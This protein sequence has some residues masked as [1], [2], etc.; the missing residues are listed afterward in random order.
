LG[1]LFFLVAIIGTIGNKQIKIR[2]TYLVSENAAGKNFYSNF[3]YNLIKI[4]TIYLSTTLFIIFLYSLTNI[5]LLDAFNLSLTT[6]SSGGFISSNY[7]S[8][9][10]TNEL[11]VFV[12]ALA[13]LFP[14]VNFYLLFNIF[15]KKFKF[16]NH[17]EDLHLIS[18]IL[19]L[20]LFF[21]FLIIPNEGFFNVFLS[22]TSSISN[23]GISI[24]SSGLDI[25]FFLILLTIVG[26]SL[27]STSSGF[28]YV[29]LY[30]LLKIS[31]NEIYRIV[32]PT[33]ISNKNLFSTESKIDDN[34]FK[35]SFLVF[36]LFI[37]SIFVLFSILSFDTLSFE[38]CF[39]LSILTLTNTV[40]SSSYG[41]DSINFLDFNSF[42][43]T[44]LI[45]FMI[46][47]R[48]EI[49]SLLYIIKKIIFKV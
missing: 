21:Y 35:I 10:I 5:R 17:Q 9:I 4:M 3:S 28:K 45:F 46:V 42:T 7:L 13:L 6:V 49:I 8:D 23:S 38:N 18:L 43:K 41:M 34:D 29:R 40:N 11:Q 22:I 31:Y 14:T 16:N 48:I 27:I 20:T 26:G 47:G 39:K 12:L 25:S 44:F 32:K 2:P 30:I 33:N 37:I 36:I 15:A 24:Y 1:G 19:F